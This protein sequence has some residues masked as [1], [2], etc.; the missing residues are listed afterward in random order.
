MNVNDYDVRLMRKD[1]Q[2]VAQHT[3]RTNIDLIHEV[4]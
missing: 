4:T 2:H 1:E 3:E